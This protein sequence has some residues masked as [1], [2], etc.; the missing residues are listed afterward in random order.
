MT[1]THVLAALLGAAVVAVAVGIVIARRRALARPVERAA[2]SRI[3][4]P[5]LG[6]AISRSALDATLR[7]ARAEHAVLVPAYVAAV[8]LTLPLDAPLPHQSELAMPLLEA[9]EQRAA[10]VNVEVDSR[11]ERGRTP[12]HGLQVMIEQERFDRVVVPAAGGEAEGFSPDDVA[13]LLDNA[14]GEIVVLRP[15]RRGDVETVTG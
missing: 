2:S 7:L 1:F 6:S 10:R 3:I 8:P 4:F 15:A 12:R 11:I 5:F 14:P 9:I 13:W